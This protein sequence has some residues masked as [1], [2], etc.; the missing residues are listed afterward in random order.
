MRGA[1]TA[2]IVAL[3]GGGAEVGG[4]RHQGFD[5]EA[6]GGDDFG[7]LV[8]HGVRRKQGRGGGHGHGNFENFGLSDIGPGVESAH[9]FR[10]AGVAQW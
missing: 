8:G 5:F 2:E 6:F 3:E 7:E 9:A 1:E 10:D 4:A